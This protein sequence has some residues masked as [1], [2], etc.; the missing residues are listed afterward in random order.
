[1]VSVIIP[2]YNVENYICR[3][4]DSLFKQTYQDFEIILVDDCGQDRSIDRAKAYIENNQWGEKV[5]YVYHDKNRG[6]SVAR[7]SGIHAA[8]GEYIFFIDGDD[9]I[10]P[11]CL[12]L[13]VHHA[14][15]DDVDYVM[16]KSDYVF[17]SGKVDSTVYSYRGSHVVACDNLVMLYRRKLILWSVCNKLIKKEFICANN[18]YFLGGVMA[19]DLLWNFCSLLYVRKVVLLD[20]HTYQYYREREGS[21]TFSAKAGSEST[22]DDL[23]EMIEKCEKKLKEA[24]PVRQVIKF[25]LELRYDYLPYCIFWH[26]YSEEKKIEILKKAFCGRFERYFLILPLCKKILFALPFLLIYQLYKMK[27][28]GSE[29]KWVIRNKIIQWVTIRKESV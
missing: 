23:L 18:L 29:F 10:S 2:V 21:T 17:P 24:L 4:L 15:Y 19:E 26:G 12:E 8:R 7:N 1:M 3:C 16:A 11:D 6:P 5:Q 9:T 27:F 14:Q 28:H 22:A 25:Y 20:T 13:M